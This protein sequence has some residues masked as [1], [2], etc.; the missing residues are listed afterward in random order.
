[1]ARIAHNPRVDCYRSV[2]RRM[3]HTNSPRLDG[4]IEV[5]AAELPQEVMILANRV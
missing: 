5:S 1:M 2:G 3:Q 4:S